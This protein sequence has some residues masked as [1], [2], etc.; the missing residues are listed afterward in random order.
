MM[1]PWTEIFKSMKWLDIIDVLLVAF[2]IYRV[3]LWFKGTRALQLTKGL[4]LVLLVYLLSKLLGLGTIDWL[5]EKLAA[6]LLIVL[7]IVFQPELRRMLERLG[8]GT[9]FSRYV[10]TSRQGTGL[11]QSL[12]RTIENLA[13]QKTGAIIVLER[14]TGMDEYIESGVILDAKVSVE[15][16]L[17]IFNTESPLHDGAVVLQG[18]RIVAAAC[19]LPLT[20]SRLVDSRLGTRHRAAIGLTEQTDAVVIVTSEETGVISV[21][22]NGVLTRYFNRQTLE[23]KLLSIYQE[24]VKE[25]LVNFDKLFQSKE[26]VSGVKKPVKV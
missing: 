26:N 16:L 3:L 18:N 15:L 10:F 12:I 11:I 22:E 8:R 14:E 24:K 2:V 7:I 20:D 25:K 21:A 17:S 19:L 6:I 1:F 13:E 9:F 4:F 5:L 23:K